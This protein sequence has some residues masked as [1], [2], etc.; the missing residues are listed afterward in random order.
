MTWKLPDDP[1]RVLGGKPRKKRQTKHTPFDLKIRSRKY[2]QSSMKR[3]KLTII[4][5]RD[6][7]PEN[8]PVMFEG[9]GMKLFCKR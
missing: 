6:R 7:L 4:K 9:L 2:G 8:K 5:E 3:V 1:C